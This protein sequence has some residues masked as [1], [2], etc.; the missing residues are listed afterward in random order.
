MEIADHWEKTEGQNALEAA[1]TA[2]ET[3]TAA[4]TFIGTCSTDEATAAK[5]VTGV[6]GFALASG[7]CIAVTFT[8]ANTA[9]SPTLDVDTTGDK[10]IML[11]GVA[12]AY[13]VAGATVQFVYDG[14]SWQVCNVPLY[15]ATATIGNP[16]S[17][18]IYIDADSFDF[19]QAMNTV[20]SLGIESYAGIY[21][22]LA[23]L[24]GANYD[25][26]KVGGSA[27]AI[28]DQRVADA[29]Y[30]RYGSCVTCGMHETGA[31]RASMVAHRG[32]G[33]LAHPYDVEAELDVGVA[34]GKSYI[35]TTADS[36]T[37]NSMH[38]RGQKT[39]WEGSWL[40]GSITVAGITAGQQLDVV[41]DG[42]VVHAAADSISVAGVTTF[43]NIPS[44]DGVY[45]LGY[46]VLNLGHSGSTVTIN[47][48]GYM[49]PSLAG[50]TVY[51]KVITKITLLG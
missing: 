12:Y 42:I 16:A 31:P 40:S 27:Y 46:I 45:R 38:V 6:T 7:A 51:S 20:A 39:L 28:L 19:R 21:N 23:L 33:T 2:Q 13:W 15:G 41:V 50:D 4:Q 17:K 44:G 5:T 3:A 18:N 29:T 32:D 37:Y 34:G 24:C 30:G 14:T 36:F 10:S 43:Y 22:L 11:N 26:V 9:A 48:A 25:G 1:A 35:N 8:N 47:K 49:C